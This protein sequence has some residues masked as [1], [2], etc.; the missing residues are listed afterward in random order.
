MSTRVWL[1]LLIHLTGQPAW[2][3][4]R[5]SFHARPK[6]LLYYQHVARNGL[7]LA[8][9]VELQER[10]S[11]FRARRTDL[12]FS[13]RA[14]TLALL[15]NYVRAAAAAAAVQQSGPCGYSLGTRAGDALPPPP[16]TTKISFSQAVFGTRRASHRQRPHSTPFQLE[17]PRQSPTRAAVV[18]KAR[19]TVNRSPCG[20]CRAD[21]GGVNERRPKRGG[22]SSAVAVVTTKL[23]VGSTILP[24]MQNGSGKCLGFLL[25]AI[26][27]DQIC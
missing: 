7:H 24:G 17:G 9:Y 26:A 20:R 8:E 21:S 14:R 25:F 10:L 15:V 11:T 3:A 1:T 12:V 5:E 13:Q 18:V 2:R 16:S 23:R 4:R 27:N 6:R 19:Y 22:K